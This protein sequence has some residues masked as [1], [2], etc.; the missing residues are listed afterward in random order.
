MKS[1]YTK[2]FLLNSLGV[3]TDI[4]VDLEKWSVYNGDSL[5]SEIYNLRVVSQQLNESAKQKKI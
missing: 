4:I 1:L 3:L 2:Q 5:S